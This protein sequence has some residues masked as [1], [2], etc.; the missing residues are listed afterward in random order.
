MLKG[1]KL[2]KKAF[3]K[4]GKVAKKLGMRF[5]REEEENAEE[6][7]FYERHEDLGDSN[8]ASIP[9]PSSPPTHP[10]PPCTSI[11]TTSNST[12]TKRSP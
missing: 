7:S 11:S 8:Q 6:L 12:S 10:A 3:G 9:R 4:L 2:L 5:E 1:L